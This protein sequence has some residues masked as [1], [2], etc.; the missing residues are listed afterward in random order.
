MLLLKIYFLEI[1][2]KNLN[3]QSNNRLT[4]R[5]KTK[6][7]KKTCSLFLFDKNES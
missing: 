1:Y 7:M 6:K 4:N 2:S 5:I 3:Y